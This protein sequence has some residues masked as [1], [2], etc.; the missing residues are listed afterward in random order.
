MY[1]RVSAE[2]S[3]AARQDARFDPCGRPLV[4]TVGTAAHPSIAAPVMACVVLE[5]LYFD[6]IPETTLMLI[7]IP[8]VLMGLFWITVL[9][10]VNFLTT[11][12]QDTSQPKGAVGE[13]AGEHLSVSSGGVVERAS[14]GSSPLK[15]RRLSPSKKDD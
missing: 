11:K 2:F 1:V 4:V 8:L 6:C 12:K 7:V 9:P 10:V 5:K 15:P 3:G 13:A 14:L